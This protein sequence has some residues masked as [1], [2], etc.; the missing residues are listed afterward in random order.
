M[1][2]AMQRSQVRAIQYLAARRPG[3]AKAAMR[4]LRLDS[5]EAAAEVLQAFAP[6]G[7]DVD[8]DLVE[9]IVATG[10]SPRPELPRLPKLLTREP[11]Q[12]I[13]TF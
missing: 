7:G 1:Q 8:L 6:A 2:G 5:E 11:R 3:E 4:F 10:S 12:E 13:W 9:S